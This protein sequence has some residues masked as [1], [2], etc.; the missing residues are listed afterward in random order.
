[1]A[2]QENRGPEA[3]RQPCVLVVDDSSV[4]RYTVVSIIKSMGYA[5]AEASDGTEV[6]A[7]VEKHQPDL[8][9]LDIHMPEKGGLETL[10][11]LRA[12]SR[13]ARLP[14]IVLTA[15][16]EPAMVRQVARLRASGYLVKSNLSAREMR[17]R[18]AKILGKPTPSPMPSAR[19]QRALQELRV[20]LVDD[21][22]LD[23]QLIGGLLS[24]W[25]CQVE[26]AGGGQEALD[27]LQGTEFD[28]VLIDYS[29]PEMDGFETT[30]RIRA[31]EVD[32]GEHLP[33]VLLSS[34]P[35]EVVK[36]RSEEVGMDA[37]VTKPVEADQL[38]TT[39]EGLAALVTSAEQVAE[40]EA[41]FD[42]EELLERVDND[43]ELLGHLF[44]LFTRDYPTLLDEIQQAIDSGKVEDLQRAA[45]TL[46]GMLGNLSAHDIAKR[47]LTLENMGREETL[48]GAEDI[49]ERLEGEVACLGGALQEFVQ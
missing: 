30:A 17:E 27:L 2:A 34:K 48:D 37:Y 40:S 18:I 11:E 12:H 32:S 28:L 39:I 19:P 42:K 15:S 49:L 4:V 25:G 7:M 46:K 20:L 6:L 29:I 14:V 10:A 1:M 47:A 3:N 8:V 21:S 24:N 35:I 43:M 26:M 13:Y 31:A 16:A 36:E 45:H 41:L 5:V 22:T 38:F 33:V 44:E 9:I 23:Q